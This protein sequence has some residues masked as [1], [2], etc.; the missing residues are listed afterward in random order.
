[1]SV[2]IAPRE[3]CPQCRLNKGRWS[4][5]NNLATYINGKFCHAGCGYL[6]STILEKINKPKIVLRKHRHHP[7]IAGTI[8]E[9]VDR[10]LSLET[11]E[12][13]NVRTTEFT[14]WLGGKHIENELVRIFPVYSNGA[15]VKQKIKSVY[16]K[17]LQIQTGDTKASEFFGQ[18]KFGAQEHL[19]NLI[20]TEGEEDAMAVFQM[21][22]VPAVSVTTGAPGGY[23]QLLANKEW[24]KQWQSILI[25]FDRD[26]VGEE[27]ANKC[28]ECFKTSKI[29]H[30]PPPFKDANE[31]LLSKSRPLAFTGALG[32]IR[33]L[34][35]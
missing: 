29:L 8:T 20:I 24:L 25:C 21:Y 19:P 32:A 35:E 18:N 2:E 17:R 22:G 13:Y 27:G 6:Q 11:C 26:K 23:K 4:E 1:M 28:L 5:G 7:L 34:E 10:G 14:G 16:N 9:L 33:L 15:L 31:I 12:V 3:Q 30:L